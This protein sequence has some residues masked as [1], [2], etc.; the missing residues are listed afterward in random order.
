MIISEWQFKV[1]TQ[2]YY[3]E[4]IMLISILLHK[5]DLD[6]D[7]NLYTLTFIKMDSKTRYHKHALIPFWILKIILFIK[8]HKEL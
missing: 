6:N 8:G 4:Q 7:C 3:H 1:C 2:K 5:H